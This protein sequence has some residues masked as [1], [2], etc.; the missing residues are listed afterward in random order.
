MTNTNYEMILWGFYQ[1]IGI[2]SIV[3][4]VTALCCM[5]SALLEGIHNRLNYRKVDTDPN[6]IIVEWLLYFIPIIGVFTLARLLLNL[7]PPPL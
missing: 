1:S 3:V 4:G 5:L 7:S 6:C 2:L